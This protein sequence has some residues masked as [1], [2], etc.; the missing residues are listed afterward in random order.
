MAREDIAQYVAIH[1]TQIYG[2]TSLKKYPFLIPYV[3]ALRPKDVLDYGCGQSHLYEIIEDLTKT[4]VFRFDPAI[5][6]LSVLEK[7]HYG[8]L[9][10]IDVLEHIPEPEL[11]EVL[12]TFSS[13]SANCLI[14]IDTKIAQTILPNGRN[15][16]VTIR[17]TTWWRTK[18]SEVFPYI[19]DIDIRDPSRA[20][21]ITFEL[22]FAQRL[23]VRVWTLVYCL[24]RSAA[25][26]C[27]P[28]RQSLELAR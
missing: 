12:V 10:N 23:A 28:S 7:S 26:R 21:F 13:L 4:S 15:A 24:R 8:L 22:S 19:R 14:V 20:A 27:S 5:E 2:N 1:K 18:L 6:E 25:R 9:I 16:H 11:H 3:K 17:P